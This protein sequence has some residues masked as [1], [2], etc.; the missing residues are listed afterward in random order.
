MTDA[1]PAWPDRVAQYLARA[2]LTKARTEPLRGDASTR[3]YVRVVPPSGQAHVLAVHAE[4]IDPGALPF[5]VVADLL[6][7]IGVRVPG[8]VGCEADLGILV[9]E[10]LGDATL[11]RSL[12]DAAVDQRRAWYLEAVAM[13]DTMQ[14]RAPELAASHPG[15]FELAFDVEKLT[16]ELEFFLTHFVGNARGITLSP[17]ARS[18]LREEFDAIARELASEPRVFCHRDYHSRNLMVRG[19]TL[20]VIDFQDARMGPDT[21]DLVSLLRDCYVDLEVGFVD[22]MVD[23]Y[24][25]LAGRGTREGFTERFDL[26]SVQRHLKALGTFGYQATAA[27]SERYLADVPR[28]L[29]YLA[30]VFD[31]RPRFGRLRAT[32]AASVAELG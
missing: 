20:Y 6:A 30:Q 21:Y 27:S 31:R 22:E 13:I 26:M 15:P 1:T 11:Q 25:R 29:Q 10:D 7:R 24:L 32:L 23:E 18:T 4:P 9:L 2:G 28:T 8:I 16:W 5:A 12:H 14:R 19:N 17:S 3:R